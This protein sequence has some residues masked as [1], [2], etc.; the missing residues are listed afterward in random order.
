MFKKYKKNKYFLLD[1]SSFLFM[2]HVLCQ[3][4]AFFVNFLLI[5]LFALQNYIN[6]EY[7]Q[8]F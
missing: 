5:F 1:Y 3:G 4:T 6:S 7:Q 2:K 8:N